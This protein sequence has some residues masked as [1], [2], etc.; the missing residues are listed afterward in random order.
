VTSQRRLDPD[1]GL[2]LASAVGAFRIASANRSIRASSLSSRP[3]LGGN[4]LLR[5][6]AQ[7]PASGWSIAG[8]AAD[9]RPFR[10]F[11]S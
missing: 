10:S 8:P 4:Q 1:D 3:I 2:P 5:Q 6:A 9:P 11:Q 7:S